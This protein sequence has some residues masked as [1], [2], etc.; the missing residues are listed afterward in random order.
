MMPRMMYGG[1]VDEKARILR[2]T[3]T[4]SQISES[5]ARLMDE[6]A[7]LRG[8]LSNMKMLAGFLGAALLMLLVAYCA[9]P[10]GALLADPG[11]DIIGPFQ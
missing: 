5:L 3:M 6:N 8:S 7:S 10:S 2:R 11:R 1:D 4:P 9:E